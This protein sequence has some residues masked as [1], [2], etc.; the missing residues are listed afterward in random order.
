MNTRL[1]NRFLKSIAN[2]GVKFHGRE[3]GERRE[4]R[5]PVYSALGDLLE[6][7]HEIL[8]AAHED[9]QIDVTEGARSSAGIKDRLQ[10]AIEIIEDP[11]AVEA[12]DG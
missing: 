11:T 10:Q 3:T 1:T 5:L 2:K 9:L 4:R 8:A 12:R 7:V 6:V